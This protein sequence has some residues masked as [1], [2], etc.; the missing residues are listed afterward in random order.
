[1]KQVY[2]LM[3]FTILALLFS[4]GLSAQSTI[5]GKVVDAETGEDLIGAAVVI[6]GIG[7]GANTDYNGEFIIKATLPVRLKITYTRAVLLQP[8]VCKQATFQ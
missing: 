1:M 6:Q 3:N 7:G 5:K 8:A 2:K 4:V